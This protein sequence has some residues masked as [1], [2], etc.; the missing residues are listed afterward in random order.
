M[1]SDLFPGLFVQ[2]RVKKH[3]AQEQLED[4]KQLEE[5]REEDEVEEGEEG[6]EED[7]AEISEAPSGEWK[8]ILSFK[9]DPFALPVIIKCDN[10]G[11]ME[12]LL[13]LLETLAGEEDLN[14]SHIM[15]LT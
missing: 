8:R 14:V 3:A 5:P 7:V 6:E 4:D 11:R 9:D 1:Y 10:V 13:T 2:P 12:T 15:S